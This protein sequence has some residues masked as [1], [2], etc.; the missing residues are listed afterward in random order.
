MALV[1]TYQLYDLLTISY[2]CFSSLGQ[3]HMKT[4][5]L[6]ILLTNPSIFSAGTQACIHLPESRIRLYKLSQQ[7]SPPSGAPAPGC[8]WIVFREFID[9]SA[10]RCCIALG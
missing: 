7:G 6:P 9:R 3:V 8:H 1:L 5:F 4:P 2:A 10:S